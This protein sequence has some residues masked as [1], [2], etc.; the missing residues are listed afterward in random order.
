[1]AFVDVLGWHKD[2]VD[3]SNQLEKNTFVYAASYCDP[4]DAAVVAGRTCTFPM[5]VFT[6]FTFSHIADGDVL[7]FTLV[8]INAFG[9]SDFADFNSMDTEAS[10]I[11]YSKPHKPIKPKTVNS[12]TD[13]V[14]TW[15]APYDG[16]S[17]ITNYTLYYR[18]ADER[19]WY[20]YDCDPADTHYVESRT[21]TFSRSMLT[22]A[23]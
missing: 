4:T 13:I 12:G 5:S 1:M 19:W 14:V 11:A 7:P 17:P 6:D 2:Q 15:D 8:A 20:S 10:A 16:G 23:E 3:E 22:N 9:Y 18:G 21:C